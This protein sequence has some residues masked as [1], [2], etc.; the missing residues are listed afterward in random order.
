MLAAACVATA[1][2]R[3]SVFGQTQLSLT[4]WFFGRK[5]QNETLFPVRLAGWPWLEWRNLPRSRE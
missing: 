4:K 2:E 5:S 3:W 1:A